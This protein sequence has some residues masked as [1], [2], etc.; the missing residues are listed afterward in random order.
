MNI[1]D[2]RGFACPEPVVMAKNAL[3]AGTGK[4]KILVDNQIAVG[5]ITRFAENKNLK[6]SVA[7]VGA[8]FELTIG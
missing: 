6:V 2:A 8:D 1:I 7:K 5:N 4:A 3:K